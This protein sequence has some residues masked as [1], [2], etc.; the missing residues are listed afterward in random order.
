MNLLSIGLEIPSQFAAVG[1]RH[2]TSSLLGKSAGEKTLDDFGKICDEV[3]RTLDFGL[4]LWY[5]LYIRT[6]V[7]MRPS[8]T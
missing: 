2:S 3:I 4:F 6:Y 7:L 1:S 5:V 8:V